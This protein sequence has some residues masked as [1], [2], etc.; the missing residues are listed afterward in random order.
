MSDYLLSQPVREEWGIERVVGAARV[1]SVLESEEQARLW[2]A[3]LSPHSK[4]RVVRRY[5]SE[6]EEA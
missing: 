2:F 6:W 3:R 1:T 5:V 4:P